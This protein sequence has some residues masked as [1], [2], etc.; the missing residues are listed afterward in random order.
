MSLQKQIQAT[1]GELRR[2]RR[3]ALRDKEY[4]IAWNLEFDEDKIQEPHLSKE[5]EEFTS[6]KEPEDFNLPKEP[7][8]NQEEKDLPICKCAAH[9]KVGDLSCIRR[10]PIQAQNFEIKNTTMTMLNSVPFCGL[11][12]EDPN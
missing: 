9:K 6:T 7:M 4:T 11:P 5:P 2:I 12:Y 10:P 3:E 8:A 1:E